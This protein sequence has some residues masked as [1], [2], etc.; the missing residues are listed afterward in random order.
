[1]NYLHFLIFNYSNQ[2]LYYY[3]NFLKKEKV[4]RSFNSSAVVII[5]VLAFLAMEE[6][7]Q[8]FP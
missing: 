6:A 2:I 8:F 7:I 5:T 1:M 4:E 3:F